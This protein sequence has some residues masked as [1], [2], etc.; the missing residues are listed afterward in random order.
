MISV[1]YWNCIRRN[2]IFLKN[3]G[4]RDQIMMHAQYFAIDE[5]FIK[6]IGKLFIESF[7]FCISLCDKKVINLY[8]LTANLKNIELKKD[9]ILNQ[10]LKINS[11]KL[12]YY[13]ASVITILFYWDKC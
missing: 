9:S 10:I 4:Q 11:Y 5:V 12:I 1:K 7:L 13:K 8:I 2:A 6:R 3:L